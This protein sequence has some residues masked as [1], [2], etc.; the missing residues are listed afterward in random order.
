MQPFELPDFYVPHPARINPHLEGARTHSKAWA[1]RLGM[2]DDTRDPGTPEIWDDRQFD[3]MDYA[4]LCAYTH[5]DCPGPELDLVTDWYVWVFYFDDHFLEV[6]KRPQDHDGAREYLARLGAFMRA[7]TPPEPANA[8]ERGLVD[9]WAR[10]V[11]GMSPDWVRRFTESTENAFNESLWELSNIS[12]QRIPNPIEYVEMRRKVGGAPWS[13]NL[14]EHAAKAEVPARVAGTRPLLV[15]RDAFSDGVHLRNDIFSYQR[16]T[17][18]EGEVNNCVLV[19]EH[20]LGLDPQQAADTVN[21]LITSRL[22]QFENTAFTELPPLFEEYGLDAAERVSVFAYVK[23]LQD[24]Q[25]GGHEWHLRS[26]RY[27]NENAR[28]SP[29]LDPAGLGTSAARLP[30]L[31]RAAA[32][33]RVFVPYQQVGPTRLPD[34]TMPYDVRLNSNLDAARR[35]GLRWCREMGMLGPVAR[36]A[37]PVWNEEELA[38]FDFALCASGINP[39]ASPDDLDLATQW[40]AWGTYGDDYFPAIFFRDRDMTGAKLFHARLPAFMPLDCGV[41]PPPATPFE[42]GLAD[43]W[44]RTATPMPM[45]LRRRIRSAVESMTESWLWELANHIQHR[46]PDPVDFIEMRRRTFGSDMTMSLARFGH[47]DVLP[48]EIFQTRTLRALE[49]AVMDYATLLND[50]FSYQKEMEFEGEIN[51]GVLVVQHFLGCGRDEAVAIVDDLMSS[52]LRQFEHLATT[53]VPLL[54]RDFDLDEQAQSA[55]TDY[56][57]EKWDWLAAILNWHQECRRYGETELRLRY[58]PRSHLGIPTGFGTS[59]LAAIPR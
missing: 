5:P 16:E 23:G 7:E 14:V 54:V 52:R 21:E 8:V 2:L 4:L 22:R 33:D 42:A 45:E 55:L 31:L 36:L 51:N 10:T 49:N 25:S 58:R 6:Y 44:R 15:L 37:E 9:L 11:P 27:M 17:E 57:Q 26:S 48:A 12:E 38:G 41:T 3:A 59:A 29:A 46:V 24:W 20:F 53:E 47:A 28:T 39:A 30:A 18:I 35:N 19:M 34:F 43:L 32:P 50:V 1:R 13:A 56:I 40:L